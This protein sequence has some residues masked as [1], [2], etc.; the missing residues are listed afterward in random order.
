MEHSYA[1]A[2][3]DVGIN[4]KPL[5]WEASCLPSAKSRLGLPSRLWFYIHGVICFCY[6]DIT[7]GTR[8]GGTASMHGP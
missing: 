1:L 4:N 2:A 5:A 6:F 8:Y 3:A 7:R